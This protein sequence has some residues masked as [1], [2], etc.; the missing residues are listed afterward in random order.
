MCRPVHKVGRRSEEGDYDSYIEELR[1][2]LGSD[3]KAKGNI[4]VFVDE[5]HRIQSG[6]FGFD[7]IKYSKYFRSR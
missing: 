7:F 2:N 5:C 4:F 6:K 3:F 1:Q